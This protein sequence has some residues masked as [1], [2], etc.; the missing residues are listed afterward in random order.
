[1][2]LFWYND[3]KL[4]DFKWS[5]PIVGGYHTILRLTIFAFT[6]PFWIENIIFLFTAKTVV[7]IRQV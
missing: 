6:A 4:R 7:V 5:N 2:W 3:S 1:M